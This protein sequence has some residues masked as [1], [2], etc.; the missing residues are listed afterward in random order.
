[1]PSVNIQFHMLPDELIEFV[2]DV[3]SRYDLGVELER[4]FPKVVREVP[5]DADLIDEIRK[6]G[7]VNRFWL[8]YKS[9]NSKRPEKFM[10][11]AGEQRGKRLAQAQL[12]AGTKKAR[13]FQVL[14]KVA[15]DLKR[16]TKGGIW[17]V[18]DVGKV[19]YINN[20]RIS[21]GAANAARAGK[22]DLVGIAFT[23][24]YYVDQPE[25]EHS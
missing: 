13:A 25:R 2:A 8:L 17:L 20:E 16:R 11:N 12:G 6:F 21:E 10:L 22:I 14:K 3:R 23:S 19:G 18:T 7:E 1:M 15:A 5:P 4:W 9:P 24:C